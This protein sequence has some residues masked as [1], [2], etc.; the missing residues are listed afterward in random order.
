MGGPNRTATKSKCRRLQIGS[1]IKWTYFKLPIIIQPYLMDSWLM[2]SW[3]QSRIVD[4]AITTDIQDVRPLK[5]ND[6]ELM[7]IF[8]QGGFQGND[9]Q[10]LNR[11]RMYLQVIYLSKICIGSST[12][13]E[14]SWWDGHRT[15]SYTSYVWPRVHKPT[16]AN[17]NLWHQAL[18]KSLNLKPNRVLPLPLGKWVSSIRQRDGFFLEN[19]GEHLLQKEGRWYIHGRIPLQKRCQTYHKQ[20]PLIKPPNIE[21]IK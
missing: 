2:S 17:W 12:A 19:P 18:Q 10:T 8:I 3:N 9:L 11:C 5:Q 6:K 15:L 20:Q 7:W 4:I 16:M 1:G 13:I 14:K 21:E